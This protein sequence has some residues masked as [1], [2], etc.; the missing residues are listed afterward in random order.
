M[1]LVR[2]AQPRMILE[3]R[4]SPLTLNGESSWFPVSCLAKGG[5]E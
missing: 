5:F 2:G 4:R 3:G 1:P